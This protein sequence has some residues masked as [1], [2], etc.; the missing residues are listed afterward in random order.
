MFSLKIWQSLCPTGKCLLRS[1]KKYLP[2]FIEK[3]CCRVD[4][5]NHIILHFPFFLDF[6]YFL[7]AVDKLPFRYIR[8]RNIKWF[9]PTYSK[10][11][12]TNVGEY[13]FRLPNKYFPP[14]RKLRTIFNRNTLKLSWSYMTKNTRKHIA[15][16]NRIMQLFEKKMLDERSLLHWKCFILH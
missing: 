10:S 13:F 7:H 15:S 1:L 9:N 11:L 6:Y 14:G 16:K 4:R 8:K 3:I 12:K 5:L 2:I